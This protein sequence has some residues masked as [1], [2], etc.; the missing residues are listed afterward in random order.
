MR[1]G[2]GGS[3]ADPIIE[4]IRGRRAI[5]CVLGAEDGSLGFRVLPVA[6]SVGTE[7]LDP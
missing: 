3:V 5:A 4:N 1:G 2:G 7:N 6:G